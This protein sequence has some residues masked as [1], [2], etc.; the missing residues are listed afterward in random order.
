MTQKLFK[1]AGQL[2]LIAAG[3]A[4]V[5]PASA[6]TDC[7]VSTSSTLN[8]VVPFSGCSVTS[9]H[10]GNPN[11]SLVSVVMKTNTSGATRRA[12]TIGLTSGGAPIGPGC[13]AADSVPNPGPGG[14]ST[15]CPVPVAKIQMK[16]QT[17]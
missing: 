9:D 7:A 1:I 3:I 12:L 10:R 15:S 14:T 5:H 8:Q 2:S 17:N 6:F 13:V 4:A 11:P 16:I